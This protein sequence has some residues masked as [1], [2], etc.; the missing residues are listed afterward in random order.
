MFLLIVY[1][2]IAL[3]FSFLCSIA[4]A[5]ILSVSSAYISVL[6]KEN[7]PSGILLRKQTDNINTPLSAILT[8]NTIA[9]TMGAAGAGAQAASVFGEAYLGVI[10]AVLTLLILVFSEI[11]PKTVGATYWRGL[12]P[13]TAYFL[14]YLIII[15]KPFV[16]MS[17]LLTRGFK[18]DSPLRGLSRGELHAMAE[19][20]GQEG[21][22]ANH[23]AVFLQSLLSL[24]ELK[25]KDAITHRTVLFS[26]AESMTVEVFF[27]KHAH[28]EYSRIPVYE[29][30][31][32]ENIT[33]YVMRS[34]LLV[35]QARGNTDKPLSEYAKDM[36][37]I[38]G[39][40]PLS[41]TFD[42]FIDKHVHMLLVV[43]EYGGLEGV[44]TLED[45][46]ERLLGVDIIDEKDTTVSMRRLAKMM[47][48]RKERMMVK[49]VPDES[50]DKSLDKSKS[51]GNDD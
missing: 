9:H 50:L 6:E 22:L 21:Q 24:H 12:A 17:E 46:L 36:V 3:G 30:K 51:N 28:I 19:L 35:A 38:L 8:L 39:S 34:D 15:L 14:K 43:D 40:M 41:I 18:D 13:V 2:L 29:D 49:N 37:T 4:E 42:H 11:I 31:D 23:E 20:S 47:T 44:I 26:V 16:V 48:R 1:V 45:L 7:R 33:G 32:S 27:H 25:V 10:S 5:V